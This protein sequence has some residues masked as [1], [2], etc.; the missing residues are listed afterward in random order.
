[1]RKSC[2]T[3]CCKTGMSDNDYNVI[4]NKI[5]CIKCC[6]NCIYL[7]YILNAVYEGRYFNNRDK[8]LDYK[9]ST[10]LFNTNP[11][12]ARSSLQ[13]YKSTSITTKHYLRKKSHIKNIFAV[14]AL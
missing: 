3:P 11:R 14:S 6:Y 10:Y 13:L 7:P 1:M 2:L 8:N 4:T 12:G 9:T 5:N